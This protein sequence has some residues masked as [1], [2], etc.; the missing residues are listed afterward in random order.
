MSAT[1]STARVISNL[2]PRHSDEVPPCSV[3]TPWPSVSCPCICGRCCQL[4][5]S[6][7]NARARDTGPGSAHRRRWD[8]NLRMRLHNGSSVSSICGLSCNTHDLPG[9]AL[10]DFTYIR[11]HY[12]LLV[13]CCLLSK[14]SQTCWRLGTSLVLLR[15]LCLCLSRS[16]GTS[17]QSCHAFSA[18]FIM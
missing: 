13:P 7:T 11:L 15:H 14:G 12:M 8:F 1:V 3:G 16:E 2:G 6:A 10:Q 4:Q 5:D 9:Q 18:F 17:Q